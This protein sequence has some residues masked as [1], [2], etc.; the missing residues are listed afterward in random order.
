MPE[1]LSHVVLQYLFSETVRL[2]CQGT[3]PSAATVPPTMRL[4]AGKEEWERIEG[5]NAREIENIDE[6]GA[7][8]CLD[9]EETFS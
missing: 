8:R 7:A 3:E 4:T 5:E 2:T 9:L 1:M 6:N